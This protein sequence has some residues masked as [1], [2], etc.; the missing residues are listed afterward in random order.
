MPK[1]FILK[2]FLLIHRA[3][4]MGMLVAEYDSDEA[5]EIYREDIRAEERQRIF[6]ELIADG[7]SPE[8]AA[9]YARVSLA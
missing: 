6:H 1:E 7:M 5:K 9:K 2:K 8:A 3:E 4:V